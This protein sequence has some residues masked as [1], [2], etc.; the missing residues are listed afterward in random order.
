[1]DAA[2]FNSLNNFI[3]GWYI[4]TDLCK[5][6]VQRQA[7]AE[8]LYNPEFQDSNKGYQKLQLEDLS[9]DLTS[10]YRKELD[11]CL[12][13]YFN[14]YTWLSSIKSFEIWKKKNGRECLQLQKYLPMR[15]YSATHCENTGNKETANRVLVFMTYLNTLDN[16]GTHFPMQNFT[17]QAEQGLT[18]I[19]PAYWTHHH[20]GVQCNETKYIITGW[21]TFTGKE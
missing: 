3:S 5:K 12:D 18:L 14:Q 15:Y 6:I 1:M 2:R 11:K 16:G 13:L 17:A 20:V 21:Y 9:E 4:S 7:E 8:H 19:W 10:Q